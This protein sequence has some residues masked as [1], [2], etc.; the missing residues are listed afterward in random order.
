MFSKNML[1]PRLVDMRLASNRA[2]VSVALPAVKGT[3][4]RM[5][6][7]GKASCARAPTA[8]KR[9]MEA[10]KVMTSL[11]IYDLLERI[12]FHRHARLIFFRSFPRQRES[13][14]ARQVVQ[15]APDVPAFARTNGR[16]GAS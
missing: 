4:N 1:R 10:K 8:G 2:S 15:F 11:F 16:R 14:A 5:F 9:P 3:T 13:R 6:C 7:D 12:R